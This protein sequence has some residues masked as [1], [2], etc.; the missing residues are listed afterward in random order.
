[1]T[2]FSFQLLHLLQFNV[3]LLKEEEKIH[4]PSFISKVAIQYRQCY[5][6]RVCVCAFKTILKVIHVPLSHSYDSSYDDDD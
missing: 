5:R 2:D 3:T 4:L 6:S 1:M